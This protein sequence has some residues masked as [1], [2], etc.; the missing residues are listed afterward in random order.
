VVR[1]V[2]WLGVVGAVVGILA[3]F[4]ALLRLRAARR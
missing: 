3:A 2:L 4:V 1:V